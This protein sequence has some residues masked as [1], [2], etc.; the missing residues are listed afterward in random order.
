MTDK[1]TKIQTKILP[2]LQSFSDTLWDHAC[3][4][5]ENNLSTLVPRRFDKILDELDT[6]LRSDD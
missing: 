5:H 2:L 4:R 1:E 3:G 6:I